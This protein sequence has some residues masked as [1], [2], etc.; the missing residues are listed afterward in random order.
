MIMK[1]DHKG[2]EQFCD[3]RQPLAD[4]EKYCEV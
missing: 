3:P 1:K 4:K 2:S